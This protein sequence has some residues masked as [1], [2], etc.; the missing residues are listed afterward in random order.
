MP[1]GSSPRVRGT[2][3]HHHRGDLRGRFIPAGAGNAACRSPP[4][5]APAVHPR[6]CGERRAAGE[7]GCHGG[8][9]SPRVRGTQIATDQHGEGVRFI[10][11]GAGNASLS[12][13][14][15][16]A[17]SV[18]PRG[19][20]ERNGAVYWMSKGN[21][22]SPRVRGT[23][24][25]ECPPGQ[26]R[27]FIPAGAGNASRATSP[28]RSPAVHP[29]GCGEREPSLTL[30]QNLSGSSPRVRGTLTDGGRGA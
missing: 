23:P 5:S 28:R 26:W 20:G 3:R 4:P 24:G 16:L 12:I 14:Q 6:G 18:H 1:S 7:G 2:P 17:S 13:P 11:A 27:R 29:R 15:R 22:S 9:S 19:C 8:G 30:R 10:P 21:G 25:R